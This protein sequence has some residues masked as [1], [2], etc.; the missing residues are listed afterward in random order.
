MV[1]C[2]PIAQQDEA[3][4]GLSVGNHLVTALVFP[5]RTTKGGDVDYGWIWPRLKVVGT[6]VVP[7]LPGPNQHE[8]IAEE[9]GAGGHTYEHLAEVD[10]DCCLEDGVG[11]EV[12]K[13]K[14]KILQ[15]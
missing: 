3:V 10:E 9:G 6:D 15:Q 5:P 1:K 12:L 4:V 14:P 13:L 2:G 11:R 8:K 7:S